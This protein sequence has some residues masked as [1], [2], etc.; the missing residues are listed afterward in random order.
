[1]VTTR[2]ENRNRKLKTYEAVNLI[3]AM[4]CVLV[5]PE[6]GW[7]YLRRVQEDDAE[8]ASDAELSNHAE[9]HSQWH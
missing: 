3:A 4:F 7:K 1:M 2:K 5:V 8:G 6:S 9:S